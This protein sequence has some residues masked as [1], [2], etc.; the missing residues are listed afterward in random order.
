MSVK[1]KSL[2]SNAESPCRVVS[3]VSQAELRPLEI[4]VVR[5]CTRRERRVTAGRSC[6]LIAPPRPRDVEH[7]AREAL[8]HR[9]F[10]IE[11]ADTDREQLVQE[12]PA[13]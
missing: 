3:V 13:Q 12:Q 11:E 4:G 10:D 5:R 1:V 6:R 8:D 2:K 9:L 7:H